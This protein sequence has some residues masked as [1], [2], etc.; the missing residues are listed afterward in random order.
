M[1]STFTVIWKKG[2]VAFYYDYYYYH[3]LATVCLPGRQV[4]SG[5]VRA[6]VSGA[7]EAVA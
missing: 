7:H 6:L 1:Q 2:C 5:M 3:G 4:R